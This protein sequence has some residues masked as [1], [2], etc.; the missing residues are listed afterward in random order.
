MRLTVSKNGQQWIFCPYRT[1]NRPSR[2]KNDKKPFFWQNEKQSYSA[3]FKD[4]DSPSSPV[5]VPWWKTAIVWL[6]YRS[7]SYEAHQGGKP[8]KTSYCQ[9][10]SQ[11]LSDISA[12]GLHQSTQHGSKRC[13]LKYHTDHVH[14]SPSE[15]KAYQNTIRDASATLYPKTYR[16]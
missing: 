14:K 15:L 13:I 12:L 11:N 6:S 1:L 16:R 10:I 2:A 8:T 4:S 5:N 3:F 7:G 9:A